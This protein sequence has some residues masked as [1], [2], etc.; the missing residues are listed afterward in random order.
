MS[1]L[2]GCRVEKT[3]VDKTFIG[4]I[5]EPL[6]AGLKPLKGRALGGRFV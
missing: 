4:S 1:Y 3:L 5:V 2:G 6:R